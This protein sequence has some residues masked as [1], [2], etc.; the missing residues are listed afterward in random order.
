MHEPLD[1]A[2]KR[3]GLREPVAYL[4]AQRELG[5]AMASYL[6]P[7]RAPTVAADERLAA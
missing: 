3:L 6:S 4:T 1:A 7:Q 5:E 2:R